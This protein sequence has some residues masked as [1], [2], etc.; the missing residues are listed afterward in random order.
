LRSTESAAGSAGCGE[1]IVRVVLHPRD[2][3]S[4]GSIKPNR[5]RRHRLRVQ[6]RTCPSGQV[7][8][9][10]ERQAAGCPPARSGRAHPR[11]TLH[12]ETTPVRAT[13]ILGEERDAIFARQAARFPVFAEYERKL[14]RTIPV[15]RLDRRT[16]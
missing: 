7:A 14:D 1:R 13:E 16:T 2:S 8:A 15:I 12:T 5:S 9:C 4:S 3:S 10:P 6:L 11:G